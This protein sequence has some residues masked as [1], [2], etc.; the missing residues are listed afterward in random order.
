[1]STATRDEADRVAGRRTVGFRPSS[2]S[3]IRILAGTLLS[4]FAIGAILMIFSTA[5][6]RVPVLQL[7]RDIPAGQQLTADDVRT[8]E[9][10]VDPSLEVVPAGDVGAVIGQYASVRM[11]AGA[12][13]Q[14]P[15]LQSNSLVAPGAAV[16][17]VVLPQG[18]LP[19]GLVE[20]SDVQLVFPIDAGAVDSAGAPAPVSGRVV[21]LPGTADPVTG[22]VSVSVEVPVEAAATVAAAAKVRLVLLAPGSAP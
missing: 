21:G 20:R 6:K 22:E 17:A 10:S 15:N 18:A 19:V 16:V 11:V 4:L 5:N 13:L 9:L 12:L 7:V 8:V 2:R 14:R 3:R 1:M